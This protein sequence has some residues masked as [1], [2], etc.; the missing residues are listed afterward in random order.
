MSPP[1][2]APYAGILPKDFLSRLSVPRQAAHYDAAIRASVGVHVAI[3]SDPDASVV[4]G[5]DGASDLGPRGNSGRIVGFITSAPTRGAPP[6]GTGS[7]AG[8]PLAE[9]E[10]ETLYVLDD[11]RDRGLG[12]RLMRAAAAHLAGLG[13]EST[14]LWVLRDNPSRWFYERLGGR[15]AAHSTTRR[16][17]ARRFRRPPMSGRRSKSWCRPPPPAP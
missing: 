17:R 10:I 13:C 8:A 9:S 2:A 1:G 16:R 6:C 7:R 14:F 4:A 15:S 3:A 5:P 12:R 11:W